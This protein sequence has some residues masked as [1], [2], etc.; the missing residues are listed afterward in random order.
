MQKL[1]E[2]VGL[3]A[4]EQKPQQDVSTLEGLLFKV[5][6]NEMADASPLGLLLMGPDVAE[7]EAVADTFCPKL[8][9]KSVLAAQRHMLHLPDQQ[10]PTVSCKQV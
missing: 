7:A 10:R 9:D 6:S 2:L 3:L 8:W 5:C 4:P 1:T